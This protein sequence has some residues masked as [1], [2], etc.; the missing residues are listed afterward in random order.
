MV[1]Y[2]TNACGPERSRC[3]LGSGCWK[4]LYPTVDHP[5]KSRAAMT[6]VWIIQQTL[7]RMMM[8]KDEIHSNP[9]KN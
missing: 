6:V 7:L 5:T 4:A 3:P 9:K 2:P 1:M 8:I